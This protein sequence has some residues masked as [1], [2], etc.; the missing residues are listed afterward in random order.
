[1]PARVLVIGLDAAEATLVEQWAAEG[2]MPA[3]AGL[4]ERSGPVRLGNPLETL[5][6]AI[7]PEITTGISG[8]TLA[9]FYHSQK[10]HTGEAGPRRIEASEVDPSQSYWAIASAGGRRIA[11]VDQVQSIVAPGL[12]GVQVMELG[13]HD[14]SFVTASDPPELLDEIR[15]RFGEYPIESCDSAHGNDEAGYLRFVDDLLRGVALKQD[16]CL[17]L[18]GRETWDLFTCTFAETHCAGHQLWHFLDPRDRKHDPNANPRL[19][20]AIREVYQ[21]VDE[22]V[23]SLIE[24]AGPDAHVLVFTSHG[25]GLYLGGYQLLPEILIRLG[26]GSGGGSTARVRSRL[27]KGVRSFL[28]RVVPGTA[29]RRL[30]QAAGTLPLPLS[31]PQ[32][33]AVTIINNR[34]GAIRLNIAGREPNGSVQPGAEAEAMLT[35]L[36][37]ELLALEDPKTGERIVKRVQTAEE[38][39]GEDHSVDLPDLIVVFR[40]D[41]GPIEECRSERVGHIR[42]PLGGNPNLPRTGDHTVESRL[43]AVGPAFADVALPED[44]NV[45]DI[46]P[47]ILAL[48]D[49]PVPDHIDGKALIITPVTV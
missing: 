2:A 44:S 14:R 36:R 28:R 1:V 3:F 10:L 43:W 46:A 19:K 9:R 13:V 26:Y 11:A 12:N 32:T 48:L 39:F 29:R 27:P 25:M 7:W 37:N 30:Q 21:R 35:D 34:C 45:L 6:G 42:I 40:T 47:T 49:V 17:D 8:G 23:G 33:R 31:S 16:L 22:A 24:A 15:R 41:L 18:L 20:G 4:M 38:A 5:P